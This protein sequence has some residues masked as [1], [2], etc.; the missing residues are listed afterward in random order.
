MKKLRIT[1]GDKVYEVSV[2]ILDEG[3]APKPMA[4]APAPVSVGSA[5]VSAPPVAA[6]AAGGA[7]APGD[8]VSPLAGK[9][10]AIDVKA[11]AS[12]NEGDQVLTIEAMKM[13]TYVYAPATGK[14]LE[15]LTN[16]GEGVEEGQVL[17]RIG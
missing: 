8:V 11:G 17:L 10:V 9:V 1:V 3:G 13:N 16:V 7:A 6:K 15:V 14:V 5:S 2:E 12:V 4:A